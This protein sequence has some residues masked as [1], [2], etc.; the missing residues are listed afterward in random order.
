MFATPPGAQ[1]GRQ[2]RTKHNKEPG[3]QTRNN[4]KIG[5]FGVFSVTSEKSFENVLPEAPLASSRGRGGDPNRAQEPPRGP[6]DGPKS[7]P[8]NSLAHPFPPKVDQSALLTPTWPPRS[9]RKPLEGHIAPLWGE[10]RPPESRK[11]APRVAKTSSMLMN[12]PGPPF[13]RS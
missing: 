13:A 11:S 3:T 1:R 6:Q 7:R 8:Y 2:L 10:K 5:L 4:Y 12:L 9:P